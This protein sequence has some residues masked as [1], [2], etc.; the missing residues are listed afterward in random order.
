MATA[1]LVF[2]AVAV[3]ALSAL[4]CNF[5]AFLNVFTAVEKSVYSAL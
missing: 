2:A 1:F 4:R 5:I 3:S